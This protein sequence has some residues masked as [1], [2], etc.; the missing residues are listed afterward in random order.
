MMNIDKLKQQLTDE[1]GYRYYPYSDNDGKTII[2]N[3]TIGVGHNLT[4][5]G[6]SKVIIDLILEDDINEVMGDLD[7]HCAFWQHLDDVRMRVLAD[8]CFNM[9]ISNLLKFIKMLFAIQSG[10]Y[11]NA[12]YELK[13][14]IWYSQ[15]GMRGPKLFNMLLT[16]LD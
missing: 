11:A 14:S 2:T 10:D 7:T 4:I 6:L 15:S 12:A 3:V 1:E 13:N 8:L 5:N 9:G 16:G